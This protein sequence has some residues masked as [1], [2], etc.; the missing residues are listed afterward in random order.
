MDVIKCNDLNVVYNGVEGG[1]CFGWL[2]R[3]EMAGGLDGWGDD[4]YVSVTDATDGGDGWKAGGELVTILSEDD[5]KAQRKAKRSKKRAVREGVRE[6]S[7]KSLQPL[8]A[9]MESSREQGEGLQVLADMFV[10]FMSPFREVALVQ[11]EEGALSQWPRVLRETS[12]TFLACAD[13]VLRPSDLI[14]FF[15]ALDFADS[16][17]APE[18]E[19]YVTGSKGADDGEEDDGSDDDDSAWPDADDSTEDASEDDSA[20]ASSEDSDDDSHVDAMSG[21]FAH[22]TDV[23]TLTKEQGDNLDAAIGKLLAA[24]KEKNQMKQ[25]ER[26]QRLKDEQA[27]LLF[28]KRVIAMISQFANRNDD[29]VSG[30]FAASFDK[31]RG[32]KEK[33]PTA[34]AM[35][36]GA[37]VEAHAFRRVEGICVCIEPLLLVYEK[38]CADI[39]RNWRRYDGGSGEAAGDRSNHLGIMVDYASLLRRTLDKLTGAW[40]V[41]YVFSSSKGLVVSGHVRSYIVG[42]LQ[43]TCER[44]LNAEPLYSTTHRWAAIRAPDEP[45]DDSSGRVGSSDRDSKAGLR[46]QHSQVVATSGIKARASTLASCIGALA[47][48]IFSILPGQSRAN[49]MSEDDAGVEHVSKMLS[50]T[51][52][53]VLKNSLVAK[54]R[55]SLYGTFPSELVARCRIVDVAVLVSLPWLEQVVSKRR[56]AGG[57]GVRT[58]L[59]ALVKNVSEYTSACKGS[60]GEGTGIRLDRELLRAAGALM[61]KGCRRFAEDG[62]ALLQADAGGPSAG[63]QDAAVDDDEDGEDT[64]GKSCPSS[65][66]KS[67]RSTLTAYLH[68][69][70]ALSAACAP[71]GGHELDLGSPQ[72]YIQ[73]CG[74]KEAEKLKKAMARLLTAGLVATTGKRK[75]LNEF[76]ARFRSRFGMDSDIEDADTASRKKLVRVARDHKM[77]QK[78]HT[79]HTS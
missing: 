56:H 63:G 31:L 36:H 21:G 67:V 51:V 23:S 60:H 38:T 32:T 77:A 52:G 7:G 78:K 72:A 19:R 35:R 11:T 58:S 4:L 61:V 15:P 74:A 8:I 3:L 47:S 6:W 37:A 10:S 53:I 79:K 9:A 55:L 17:S 68:A 14:G 76:A 44:A 29:R 30:A 50:G 59:G 43:R 24:Q 2:A 12:T 54:K 62:V 20:G 13:T 39:M 5:R 49:I 73:W 26:Q 48:V 57:F 70:V 66:A 25:E 64:D 33:A 41:K 1:L 42:G 18:A 71:H 69:I 75:P 27:L 65:T 46:D 34:S 16:E 22:G 28:R 40:C 45:D